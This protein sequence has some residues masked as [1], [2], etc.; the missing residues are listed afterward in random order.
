MF[1]RYIENIRR[2]VFKNRIKIILFKIK[3]FFKIRNTEEWY[4]LKE[5]Y[6]KLIK[7]NAQQIGEDESCYY[8]KVNS[9]NCK[10]RKRP[11]SDLS[12]FCQVFEDNEY[13]VV[14]DSYIANFKKEPQTIIDAGANIGLASL[15]FHTMLNEANIIAIE[16]DHKNHEILKY[17][18]DRNSVN[19][20]IL[21]A[22]LW[23][24]NTYLKLINNFRDKKEWSVR[25]EETDSQGLLAVTVNNLIK[26]HNWE[27]IDILK[28]DI[29]GAEKEVFTAEIADVSF[30]SKTKCIAIEIH[31]EFNCREAINTILKQYHFDCFN[32]GE[33][34]IGVNTKLLPY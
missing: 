25:V 17:N 32:A 31:D 19:A 34:T 15:Y 4:G 1:N 13:G 12:V 8:T 5:Y 28:I 26:Q 11:S 20:S 16:P 27:F 23:S 3:R 30:L 10:L 14:I 2:L 7:L 18:L 33:L 21:N 6:L 9:L 24:K 29:E 22:G